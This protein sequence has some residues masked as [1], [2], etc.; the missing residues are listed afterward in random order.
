MRH[1]TRLA[2]LP[3]HAP[4]SI[5]QQSRDIPPR[6]HRRVIN[7]RKGHTP[8]RW[9][10]GRAWRGPR[11]APGS[12][13]RPVGAH[14]RRRTLL[15]T[16]S[17]SHRFHALSMERRPWA[18][19][20]VLRMSSEPRDLLQEARASYGWVGTGGFTKRPWTRSLGS[21]IKA[22]PGETSRHPHCTRR[23]TR[24]HIQDARPQALRVPDVGT[25]PLAHACAL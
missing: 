14:A 20:G 4:R 17:L 6:T 13:D 16:R 1:H 11:P 21:R 10:E 5:L 22:V 19:H 25:G 9:A 24:Q 8:R 18:P 12:G 23:S 3:V 15:T 7:G 2:C